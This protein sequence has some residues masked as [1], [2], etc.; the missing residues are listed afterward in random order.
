MDEMCC[1]PDYSYEIGRYV[2]A[3]WCEGDDEV[4]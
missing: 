3:E 4:R 2:H 1:E